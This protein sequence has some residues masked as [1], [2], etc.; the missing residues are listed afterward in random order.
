MAGVLADDLVVVAAD[1]HELPALPAAVLTGELLDLRAGFERVLGDLDAELAVLALHPVVAVALGGE[2]EVLRAEAVAVPL[3]DPAAVLA[4]VGRDIHAVGA[5]R[6]E[7]P[8][9]RSADHA[10]VSSGTDRGAG[11]EERLAVAVAE[12][13]GEL[14]DLRAVGRTDQR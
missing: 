2:L 9:R 3:L 13:A 12:V 6:A 1:V 4:G 11:R 10:G 5:L 14:Q 8:V 7:Q